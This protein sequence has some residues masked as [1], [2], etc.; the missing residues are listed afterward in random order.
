MAGPIVDIHPHIISL[1][2]NRYPL[3]PLFGIQSDWS[4]E[5]PASDEDFIAA[6]DDAGVAKAAIVHASTC[7]GFD[8]SYVADAVARF[9]NRCTAVG[10]I[11]MLAPDAV[12]EANRWLDRGLTGFRIFTGGSTKKVDASALDDPRSY[13]VWELMGERGLSICVQTDPTGLPA[14]ISLAK[15]FPKVAV[16]VDHLARPDVR[17]G[18]SFSAAAPLFSLATLPNIYLK[19]TPVILARLRDGGADV[20]AFISKVVSEFGSSRIAWGSNWPNS[21]GTLTEIV[22]E[23]KS[24]ISHLSAADQDEIMGG[25]ALRLYPVLQK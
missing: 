10:S 24:A 7:Y 18:P 15:R 13:P 21:P 20:S 3:A 19:Y 4:K 17:G 8:N 2:T 23:A 12:K 11:D 5:R 9:P 1:D 14:A 16:I 6:M 22:E 25:T